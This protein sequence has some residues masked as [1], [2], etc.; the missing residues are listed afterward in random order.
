MGNCTHKILVLHW[1]AYQLNH[2]QNE[3]GHLAACVVHWT[4]ALLIFRISSPPKAAVIDQL[5]DQRWLA[6]A[7]AAC[8]KHPRASG[9]QRLLH[10]ADK[11]VSTQEQRVRLLQGHLKEQ[12]LQSKLWGTVL[13]KPNCKHNRIWNQTFWKCYMKYSVCSPLSTSVLCRRLQRAKIPDAVWIQF[14]LLKMGMLML[15]TCRG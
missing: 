6:G 15:E 9:A 3:M 14:F 1:K 8:N 5:Q 4:L 2:E 10:L 12:R 11:P 7:R 13:C